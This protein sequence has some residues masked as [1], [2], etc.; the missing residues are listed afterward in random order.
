[1]IGGVGGWTA[2][3]TAEP[4]GG[5]QVVGMRCEGVDGH[6]SI[7]P[8]KNGDKERQE[9]VNNVGFIKIL[10]DTQIFGKATED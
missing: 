9:H 4:D 1:M 6:T 5:L 7:S 2:A 8:P 10:D 3:K